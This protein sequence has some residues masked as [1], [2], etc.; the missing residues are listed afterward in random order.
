MARNRTIY[1]VLALYASQVTATGVQTGVNSIKQLS[2]IQSFDEDF[3]RTFTDVN[4]YGSLGAIDRIEVETPTVS[5]SF[6]YY[7]TDGSNEDAIGLTVTRGAADPMTIVSGIL[8][9]AGGLG[10]KNYYLLIA[11]EGQDAN[12]YTS[13]QTGVIGV[14]N[15]FL[16]S[17]SV[18]AAVGDIPMASVDLEALNLN[19]F[20]TVATGAQSPAVSP[21]NGQ[22]V[23]TSVYTLPTATAIT[24]SSTAMALQPGDITFSIPTS[25]ALGWTTSDL[26]IQD[27]SLSFDLSRTP[28]Q[29]LGSRFAFSREIDFPVVATL[30]VNAEVG[31]LD[32]GSLSDIT[33]LN[34]EHDFVI[35]LAQA[36]CA[37]DG[38]AAMIYSFK[39]AKLTSQNLSTSIGSNAT[40][41]ATYEVQ[42]GG[43]QDTSKGI[44]L[45]GSYA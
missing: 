33:C 21:D 30:E 36:S 22:P 31:D 28:L 18:S 9:T 42:I 19:V 44:F 8:N 34:A 45:S 1:Q 10:E 32:D 7:L 35:R 25:G 16:T 27:F 4:Q 41:S 12:G 17:Y 43:P 24:G 3:S 5:S 40:M 2:R 29:K 39:G 15:G 6:S 11:D 13:A 37:G 20:G 23:A 38:D 26:K 14:G